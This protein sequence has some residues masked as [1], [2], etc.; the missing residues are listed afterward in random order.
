MPSQKRPIAAGLERG[1]RAAEGGPAG[2]RLGPD[3]G[4]AV[5]VRRRGRI[6]QFDAAEVAVGPE[7]AADLVAR[8]AIEQE[9]AG[10][11]P[12]PVVL[13]PH[14]QPVLV[15]EIAESADVIAGHAVGHHPPHVPEES[16]RLV[17]AADDAAG[18]HRQIAAADRSRSGAGS[19]RQSRRSN[20]AGPSRSCRP[21]RASAH[22]AGP[23]AS[24]RAVCRRRR[25]NATSARCGSSCPLRGRSPPAG[26]ARSSSRSAS[27]PPAARSTRPRARPSEA[28]RRRSCAGRYCARSAGFT[29]SSGRS[30]SA[31]AGQV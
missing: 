8:A 10:E 3:H 24:A 18:Q 23:A 2:E 20:S 29:M 14:F 28:C 17:G 19:R 13:E 15:A 11:S 30:G 16:V 21:R 22:A 1:G 4:F 5:D 25:R 27:S 31:G 6:A 9:L 26:R 12:V 7:L